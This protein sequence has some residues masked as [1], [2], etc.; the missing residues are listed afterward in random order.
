VEPAATARPAGQRTPFVAPEE[1][2]AA[3]DRKAGLRQ[4]AESEV[5]RRPLSD[6]EQTRV[7]LHQSSQPLTCLRGILELA[8]L[9]DADEQEYRKAIQQSLAQAEELVQLFKSYRAA[10]EAG[11]GGSVHQGMEPD[12]ESWK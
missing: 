2:P 1:L 12:K 11:A 10:I 3:A 9:L 8:L 5:W 4:G 7:F 6:R